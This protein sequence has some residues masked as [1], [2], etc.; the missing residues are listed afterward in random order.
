MKKHNFLKTF[1]GLLSAVI[2]S[3]SFAGLIAMTS[4][5]SFLQ[6]FTCLMGLSFAVGLLGT[7]KER[8]QNAAL[9]GLLKEVWLDDLLEGFWDS[10]EFLQDGDDWDSFVDND[11]INLAEVGAA[12][13]V[14]KNSAVYPVPIAPR[15]D[16]PSSVSL[17]LYETENTVHR[18]LS[19][20]GLPY[21]KQQSIINQ[22]RNALLQQIADDGIYDIAPVDNTENGGTVLFTTGDADA[23]LGVL[24]PTEDDFARLAAL[25]DNNK[26]IGERV[27]NMPPDMFWKFVT[28][29]AVLKAQAERNGKGGSGTGK[30]S[31]VELYD[32]TIRSRVTTVRYSSLGVKQAQGA[33]TGLP[34]AVAYIKKQSFGRCIGTPEMFFDE[35]DA[36]ERGDIIGF[37]VNAFVGR[38]RTATT[39]ALAFA[40]AP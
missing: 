21:K 18:G 15:T 3:I 37:G 40:P 30:A 7:G 2:L 34:A 29:S 28:R 8:I 11:K 12:P 38:K 25:Y 13:T 39:A 14:R 24:L 27:V 32:F 4:P 16:T 1:N 33:L 26:W 17:I 35:K 36:R 9:A 5:L 31:F 19:E 20:P 23:T 6:A 22:H 10:N